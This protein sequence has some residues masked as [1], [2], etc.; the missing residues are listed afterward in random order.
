ML[1]EVGRMLSSSHTSPTGLP[2]GAVTVEA[3]RTTAIAAEGLT[4]RFGD[5][6]AVDHIDLRVKEGEVF[7]FLGPNGAGK[8]TTIR[9]LT[10]LTPPSGGR[11]CVAGHD[12]M[13]DPL[14]AKRNFA[15]VPETSNAYDELTVWGNLMFAGELHAMP[16]SRREAV[17][18]DMLGLLALTEHRQK[19]GGHLSKGLKRRLVLAMA[20]MSSPRILFLDEPSSGLDVDSTRM[21]RELVRRLASGG[22]TV[23]LTT[24][25]IEEAN[26]VC[27]RV[28]I[29][30]RGR[31][32]A[33]GAPEEL[34]MTVDASRSVEVAL[35]ED[36]PSMEGALSALPSV[37]QVRREGDKWRLFT[38]SP[39][40]VLDAL[41]GLIHDEGLHPVSINTLGPSLEDVFVALTREDARG[42]GPA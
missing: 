2:H 9:M 41:A 16:R 10:T 3:S 33:T 37:T 14:N 15:V 42:G 26:R 12:V 21:L 25:N 38:P 24:H 23:F 27:D 22:M 8:T 5:L 6:V 17:A 39:P 11:A 29:I 1:D 20:L 28:A 34:R 31:I 36:R 19:R 30:V 4:K 32:V 35:R 40:E 7:G 13:M 18:E